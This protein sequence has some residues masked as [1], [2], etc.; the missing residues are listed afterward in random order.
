VYNKDWPY[1]S[2][3]NRFAS[4]SDCGE[5]RSMPLPSRVTSFCL[6]FLAGVGAA[7]AAWWTYSQRDSHPSQLLSSPIPDADPSG[8][9][10]TDS[11]LALHPALIDRKFDAAIR[12]VV[13]REDPELD[14]WETERFSEL[15]LKQLDELGALLTHPS[16]IERSQVEPLCAATFS[17]EALRP[18]VLHVVYEDPSFI[19]SRAAAMVAPKT[20]GHRGLDGLLSA[21]RQQVQPF[22]EATDLYFK[23]KI[24]R[25]ELRGNAAATTAYFQMNGRTHNGRIQVNA[26]WN[27]N[28]GVDA[29]TEMPKLQGVNVSDYE[30]VTSPHREALFADCTES[31][32]S[33]PS[34]LREQLVYGRDHWYGN[35]EVSLGV[36]GRGNGI[37]IADVDGDGRQ[38]VYLCQPAALP[39]RLLLR[40][41]DGTLRDVSAAAGVD[42]L[43]SSRGALFVDVDNDGDQDL[44][45]AHSTQIVVQ[46]NNGEG[47]FQVRSVISTTSRLFSLSAIDYDSDGDLD[48]YV[49]GYAS[50]SQTRPEDVF[51]SPVPYH[52]ANNGAPNVL[53]RNDGDWSFTD[54]TRLVG[55][56]VNNLRF[57]LAAAWEDVDNDGDP[58]LYVA[59]DFGR[60]NLYRNDAGRFVDIAA[61]AGVEDIGPGMSVAWGDYNHDGWMDIYVSNM[62]SS[63]GSRITHNAQFKPEADS[64]DLSGFRR[65]ARGNSLL[66]NLGDGTFEDRS[67][68]LGVTMGR[69]AWGSLFT[70]INNDGWQDLYVTNGFV[71]ADNNNDL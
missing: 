22:A 11:Q 14:G 61:E 9:N 57:S 59:N 3:T 23:F 69:W 7:S 13:V 26:T 65:H 36:E 18:P 51:V 43:D 1:I 48:V 42:W 35:L 60:N 16:Q 15:A 70:D 53:L 54:V 50:A 24:V 39:N 63:A 2:K 41:A 38:D 31:A 19:V 64:R 37:A 45:L 20:P 47:V 17:S 67:V 27:C 55:L 58:D 30:E 34:I 10:A 62:F 28:W 29:G 6:L 12:D 32:F 33:D 40:N 68:D 49:C 46:E 52:D 25:V 66:E 44:V 56:D 8:R 4:R 5:R 71:T 21:L